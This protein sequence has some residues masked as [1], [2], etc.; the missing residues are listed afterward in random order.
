[1]KKVYESYRPQGPAR[2]RI[3]QINEI[4]EY[5][6]LSGFILTIRSIYYRLVGKDIIENNL[7][8]YKGIATT[9][10][11][12]RLAGMIDWDAIVDE[13]RYLREHNSWDS[14]SSII[15]AAANSFHTDYWQGQR[16]RPELWI[17]KDAILGVIGPLCKEYDLPYFSCRGNPSDASMFL[18]GQRML[19]YKANGQIP[20]VFYLGDHDPQGLDID[21]DV[22]RKLTLFTGSHVPFRRLALTTDQIIARNLPPNPVKKTDKETG[23]V[24][25]YI[26]KYGV[27]CWELDALDPNELVGI[28][29]EAIL[30]KV[31][32][33]LLNEMKDREDRG[34]AELLMVG[35]NWGD[36]TESLTR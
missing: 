7:E 30:E 33:G 36:I 22:Q 17:E 16:Y 19:E 21:R 12:A 20:Y 3:L 10:R 24:V 34:R 2:E 32:L 9:I 14:P 1:M 15:L 8:S 6:G 13:T 31:D 18:A 4:I 11:R 27:E 5:F 28:V 35:R 29:K 26:K 23:P 25:D